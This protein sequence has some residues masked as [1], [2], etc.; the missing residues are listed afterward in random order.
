MADFMPEHPGRILRDEFL[1][2]LGISEY[3]LSKAIGV[4]QSRISAIV[5][6]NRSISADTGLRISKAL[7]LSEMF[8]INMQ[9]RYDADIAKVAHGAELSTIAEFATN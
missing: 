2:P 6:G 3:A 7:G 5:N 1:E 9:A 4:P 8:W